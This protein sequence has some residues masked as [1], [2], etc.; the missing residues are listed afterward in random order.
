MGDIGTILIIEESKVIK[1]LIF[2]KTCTLNNI[3]L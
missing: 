2:A 1:P 3:E